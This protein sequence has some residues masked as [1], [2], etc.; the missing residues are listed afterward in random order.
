DLLDT[1]YSSLNIPS[2]GLVGYLLSRLART[3][4]DL[5]RARD[6]LARRAVAEQRLSFAKDLHDLLGLGLSAIALKG[7]LVHRQI[8]K[9]AD[10]ARATLAEIT[11]IAQQALSDVRAVARG[12]RE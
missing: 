5:H 10:G 12:Y 11:D 2:S 6:E 9:S 1:A 7:E 4:A 3:V 8:R